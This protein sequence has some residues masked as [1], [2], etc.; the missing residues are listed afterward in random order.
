MPFQAQL[1]SLGSKPV[2]RAFLMPVTYL[3][4]FTFAFPILP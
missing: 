3:R 2:A 4:H 1:W